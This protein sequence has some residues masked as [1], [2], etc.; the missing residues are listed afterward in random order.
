MSQCESEVRQCESE[1]SQ[2]ESEV[3]LVI[4]KFTMSSYLGHSRGWVVILNFEKTVV[5]I[6][7]TVNFLDKQCCSR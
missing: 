6:I 4:F 5:W 7:S 2:C 3:R 1:V